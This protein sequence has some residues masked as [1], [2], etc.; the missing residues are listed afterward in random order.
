MHESH[1]HF[2]LGSSSSSAGF[3]H[4]PEWM[5]LQGPRRSARELP[6]TRGSTP[7]AWLTLVVNVRDRSSSR[8][9]SCCSLAYRRCWKFRRAVC[10]CWTS[11]FNWSTRLELMEREITLQEPGAAHLLWPGV[12]FKMS[13]CFSLHRCMLPPPKSSDFEGGW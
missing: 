1:C 12:V 6:R 4:P 3:R 11:Y 2:R 7:R 9:L 8:C 13:P 5:K 10:R